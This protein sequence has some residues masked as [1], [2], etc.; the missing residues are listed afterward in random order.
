MMFW[1]TVETGVREIFSHKFRSFLSM[2]GIVLGVSSL[3]A[4]MALTTGI[5]R[6]TRMFMAQMGGIEMVRIVDK[7]I[8]DENIDLWNLSPGRTLQDAE[9]IRRSAPLVSFVSPEIDDGMPV[10][11]GANRFRG[12]VRGVWPEYAEATDTKLEYGRLLSDL[13]IERASRTVV[14]GATIAEEL[15]PFLEPEQTLGRTMFIR[16]APFEVV[17]VFGLY[18]RDQLNNDEQAKRRE[19]RGDTRRRRDPFR[20]KN[21][22]VVIPI[23]TMFYEFQSGN[24]PEDTLDTVRLKDLTFRVSDMN[25]FEATLRQVR[26]ALDKTHRGVDDFGFDTREDWFDNMN[27]SIAST[28]TSGGLIAGICLLVGGIGIA[29]IMLASISERVHEIGIRRAVGARGR[30]IFLQIIIE[31]VSTALLGGVLGVFVGFG[32]IE[33]ISVI[34]PSETPPFVTPASVILSVSFAALAG[35]LSGIY[36]AV[37]ASRLEPIQALRYE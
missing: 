3:I 31:S 13:D 30:D 34:A 1:I 10:S 24:F 22:A 28:R 7:E 27:A 9:A 23:S 26:A 32:L 16:S 29:N 6:S 36:P 37:Q 20:W 18:E 5:E 21:E 2:L 19:K 15:W 25:H 11:A 4:T 35:V 17:G 33:L 14:I 12:R 8:S